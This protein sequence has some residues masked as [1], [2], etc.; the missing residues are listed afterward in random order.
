[1]TATVEYDGNTYEG[2]VTEISLSA[3][4]QRHAFYAQIIFPNNS[5][6]LKSGLTVSVKINIYKNDNAIVIERNLVQSD[7]NG[8]FVYVYRDDKAYKRYLTLGNEMDIYYEINDGIDEGENLI[9]KGSSKLF[10]KAQVKLI[11]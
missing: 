8:D 7:Q 3:D 6:K 9:V 2:K 11:D 4:P 10:D 5:M 1:M